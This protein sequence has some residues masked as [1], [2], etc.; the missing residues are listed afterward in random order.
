MRAPIATSLFLVLG[1][2]AANAQEQEQK[3]LDRL[4]KPDVSLQNHAGEKQFVAAGTVTGKQAHT[5]SFHISQRSLEKEYAGVRPF[6]AKEFS[7]AQSRL[8]RKE[9]NTTTR[10]KLAK[11]DQPYATAAYVTQNARESGKAMPVADYAEARRSFLGRGK[12]QKTLS[13][14]DRSMTIDEVR[15]LLNKNK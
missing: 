12:S 5:K 2:A 13:A 4:L 14:Q 9:A 15:E 3:L 10:N 1:L 11:V 6:Q 8:A 7:T